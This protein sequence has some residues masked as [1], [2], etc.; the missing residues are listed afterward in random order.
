MVVAPLEVDGQWRPTVL[1]GAT[2]PVDGD[3]AQE[4]FGAAT[5]PSKFE[6]LSCQWAVERHV[7][8]T[9]AASSHPV[10]RTPIAEV[11]SREQPALDMAFMR[12]RRCWSPDP[13]QTPNAIRSVP[14]GR[15]PKLCPASCAL[16]RLIGWRAKERSAGP[17]GLHP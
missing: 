17:C 16:W 6:V 8:R 5:N 15:G 11:P 4:A 12:H 10:G 2:M 9:R 13:L 1:T 14:R 3:A 7:G